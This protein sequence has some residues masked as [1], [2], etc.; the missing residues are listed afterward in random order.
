MGGRI[1]RRERLDRN[2]PMLTWSGWH[3]ACRIIF[4]A[5]AAGRDSAAANGTGCDPPDDARLPMSDL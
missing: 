1:R 2:S 5:V 4:L 3:R